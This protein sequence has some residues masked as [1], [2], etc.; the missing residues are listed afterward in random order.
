[1]TRA[2]ATFPRWPTGIRRTCPAAA[3]SRRGRS[4][5][6]SVSSG[7]CSPRDEFVP[8]AYLNGTEI[9]HV[10]AALR[11]RNPPPEVLAAFLEV[12]ADDGQFVR[13]QR[14]VAATLGYP[15]AE[16]PEA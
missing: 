1:M 13:T 10:E 8:N 12:P 5:R 7:A 16:E 4:G 3:R 14:L 6:R 11:R 2:S 9:F 15:F